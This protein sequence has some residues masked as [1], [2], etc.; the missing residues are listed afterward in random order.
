VP[1]CTVQRVYRLSCRLLSPIYCEWYCGVNHCVHSSLRWP[2][3]AYFIAQ[4]HQ[5]GTAYSTGGNFAL[6]R[7]RLSPASTMTSNATAALY[8]RYWIFGFDLITAVNPPAITMPCIAKAIPATSIGVH[9]LPIG[10]MN[11]AMADTWLRYKRAMCCTIS[12]SP[13]SV[14]ARYIK[15]TVSGRPM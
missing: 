4:R 1:K 15:R 9:A 3:T 6:T 14:Q 2:P 7:R 5:V 8:P 13:S 12:G 11:S 10:G